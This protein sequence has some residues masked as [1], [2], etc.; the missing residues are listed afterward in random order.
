MLFFVTIPILIF[1]SNKLN[2]PIRT[3][4]LQLIL[5]IAVPL[6]V[7]LI[8]FFFVEICSFIDGIVFYFVISIVSG[9]IAS[10][11]AE[12]I[13]I[14]SPK[15][16]YLLLFVSL[17]ILISIPLLELYFNPQIYFYSPLIGFFPGSIY[18]EDI[19]VD[20]KL[21][22]YRVL[23]LLFVFSLFLIFRKNIFKK[24]IIPVL[25]ILGGLI[26]SF[27][28]SPILGFSTTESRLNKILPNKI[29]INNFEIHYDKI[30]SLE[31][32]VIL[33]HHNYYYLELKKSIKT[34]PRRKVT[35]YL[36]NN[37]EDKRIYFG[38]GNADV[39][40]PWL[41]QIYLD[42]NSW[43]TTLNHELAHVFSA[44][45]GNSLLKLAGDYNPF[46]IEGF[47]TAKDPF[48]DIYNIDHLA[49]IH[50]KNSN[51]NILREIYN[52][53]NIFG[54]NSTVSYI[55]S[56]SFS[57]YLIENYGIDKF[58]RYYANNNFEEVYKKEFTAVS[59]EYFDYL[60]N[61]SVDSNQS[62][63]SYYFGRK[64]LIQKDC[65]RYI[66]KKIKEGWRLFEEGE[67]AESKEI[68]QNVLS[69]TENYSALVGLSECLIKEKS[70]SEVANI[71]E[72]FIPKFANTPYEFLLRLR[73]ADVYGI[74]ENY[75]KALELYSKL[76]SDEPNFSLQT[77]SDFRIKLLE[78]KLFKDYL[79]ADD[80]TKLKILLKLN[81]DIYY[82]SSIPIVIALSKNLKI[83]YDE[84]L[85]FFD[86]PFVNF[87]EYSF[88]SFLKLSQ[89][90][91]D[92]LDFTRARKMA[93]L[94]RRL[95]Q[96]YAF[97]DYL[98][99]NYKMAEWFYFNSGNFQ[100]IK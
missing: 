28:I 65:P 18:D 10:L 43:R 24:K 93:A 70:F 80:S 76:E 61:L 46:L 68:F 96:N 52:G 2:R 35:V 88:Y 81:Q 19:N 22:T 40:K 20:F 21:I 71:L 8:H 82:Y 58:K 78:K 51:K 99:D 34:T 63:Y 50:H 38:S 55:Y 79:L 37:D 9:L 100:Q 53:L 66:A 15:K 72:S 91:I 14:I 95:N 62:L 33:L 11:L 57:K 49:A 12:I 25:L 47:A 86:K 42:R 45:F 27:F 77:L 97:A 73:L 4:F 83:D 7:V 56:G 23:N 26:T 98:D 85:S 31:Q 87:D 48:F 1:Q 30:D 29:G 75:D 59:N 39:S 17:I 67:F 69:H 44:E 74:T 32:K 3:K 60:K 90:M 54:F 84:F 94:S 92:N 6:F 36:F 89:Y 16:H 41:Y 5:L 64:A 13:F